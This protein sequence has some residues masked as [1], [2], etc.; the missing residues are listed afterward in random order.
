MTGMDPGTKEQALRDAVSD[1]GVAV[2]LKGGH[3]T[4]STV[5]D[6]LVLG[7]RREV[8][9]SPRQQTRNTHGTGC[10]LSAA[11]AAR[12]ARGEP[13]EMAVRGG[14]EFVQS[15]MRGAFDLGRG[16]GPLDHL[17]RLE[18]PDL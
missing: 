1:L 10:T 8:I 17:V 13:L 3:G 4:G 11:I 9:K 5:E 2:L 16:H 7:E 12:L 14:V 18:G 15:A 6:V